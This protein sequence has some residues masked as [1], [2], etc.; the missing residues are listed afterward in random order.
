[1]GRSASVSKGSM[2]SQAYRVVVVAWDAYAYDQALPNPL[3]SSR[4]YVN[5][6]AKGTSPD[7]MKRMLQEVRVVTFL[8]PVCV[9][10]CI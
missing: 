10:V 9:C 7:I 4:V 8:A 5:K 3:I 2:W 1:M 6:F